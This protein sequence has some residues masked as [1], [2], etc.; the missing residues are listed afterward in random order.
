MATILD[1]M[2]RVYSRNNPTSDMCAKLAGVGV[3]SFTRSSLKSLR[4]LGSSTRPAEH[5]GGKS[6]RTGKP[7]ASDVCGWHV[8]RTWCDKQQASAAAV[9]TGVDGAGD[10]APILPSLPSLSYI[11]FPSLLLEKIWNARTRRMLEKRRVASPAVA[12]TSATHTAMEHHLTFVATRESVG[13][14]G[15]FRVN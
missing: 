13:I 4:S 1:W 3:W 15:P 7:S 11:C 5:T 6:R 12:E 8:V 2:S 10:P 9:E 14:P